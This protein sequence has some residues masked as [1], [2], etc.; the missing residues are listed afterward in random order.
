MVISLQEAVRWMLSGKTPFGASSGM[1]DYN[2]SGSRSWSGRERQQ[3][4]RAWKV[5]RKNFGVLNNS[6][7]YTSRVSDIENIAY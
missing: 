2:Y 6:V 5:H 4:R 1:T 7:S 3:F